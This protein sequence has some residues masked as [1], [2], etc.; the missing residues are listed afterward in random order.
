MQLYHL[1]LGYIGK[2]L[3][4]QI[5]VFQRV[6]GEWYDA[7]IVI[8]YTQPQSQSFQA[9]Q[10]WESIKLPK[11]RQSFFKEILFVIGHLLFKNR[12][13]RIGISQASLRVCL[14]LFWIVAGYW[15]SFYVNQKRAFIF[16]IIDVFLYSPT[17]NS[18][19]IRIHVSQSLADLFCKI[20]KR[21]VMIPTA[22][23][24][25]EYLISG[26]CILVCRHNFYFWCKSTCI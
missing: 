18:V 23:K 2:Q 24:L 13:R 7:S 21:I 8:S 26:H 11:H 4:Q 17:T 22:Q 14:L 20:I 5:G 9:I 25:V 15:I 1:F 19:S 16:Q 6:F 10:I 3:S 12:E